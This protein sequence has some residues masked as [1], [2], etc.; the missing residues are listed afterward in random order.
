MS[1][2]ASWADAGGAGPGCFQ[3]PVWAPW[4]DASE[5]LAVSGRADASKALAASGC[6]AGPRQQMP[7]TLALKASGCQVVTVWMNVP[8][9]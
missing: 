3:L 7:V 9:R 5:A 2:A 8:L 6:L 4:A 1:G